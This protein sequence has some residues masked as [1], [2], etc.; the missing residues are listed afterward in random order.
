[1]LPGGTRL[2]AVAFGGLA[3]RCRE[4][5]KGAAPGFAQGRGHCAAAAACQGSLPEGERL[6]NLG[7]QPSCGA[8][9]T[10]PA[11]PP[12][13]SC[14]GPSSCSPSLLQ[15][16]QLLAPLAPSPAPAAYPQEAAA[17]KRLADTVP[18]GGGFE[19]RE[20]L[21]AAVRLRERA[22]LARTEFVAAQQAKALRRR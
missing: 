4:A 17:D 5:L 14:S 1:V 11:P 13:C 7:T 21:C 16:S 9:H 6:Y 10:R 3:R 22:I 19:Q 12:P 2:E 15:P 18:E 8:V 20:A